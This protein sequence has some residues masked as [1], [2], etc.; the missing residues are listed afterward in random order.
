MA[1][2]A[3]LLAAVLA[4]PDD[5]A[6]RL[7]YA[8]ALEDSDPVRAEFIKIQVTLAVWRR[9]RATP[10]ARTDA[11]LRE[12]ELIR[13]H[14]ATWGADLRGLVDKWVFIRGFA[15]WV[16]LDARAFLTSAPELYRRTPV[17]HLDLTGAKPVATQLFA[18]AHLARLASLGLANNALGDA[19][20]TALAGSTHLGKLA[21]LDLSRNAIGQPGL[22]ALAAS[23]HLP[24]L[25]YLRFD[26]NR[27]PDPTPAHADEYDAD[28]ALATALQTKYGT[29]DWLDA[30]R[31]PEWPP[32]RLAI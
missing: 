5:D 12:G 24:R 9:N 26:Q 17:R 25:G 18:S 28:S 2:L 3:A 6:P 29:R 10:E 8:D 7:A 22:E 27:V 19:E 21:W 23:T 11:V 15:E 4:A 30:R 16:T 31:R 14:G 20:A 32:D 1:N 13:S